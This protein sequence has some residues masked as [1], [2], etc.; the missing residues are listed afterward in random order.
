MSARRLLRALALAACGLCL[1]FA[2]RA[3]QRAEALYPPF[4]RL[5]NINVWARDEHAAEGHAAAIA[6]DI[7][8]LVAA[9]APVPLPAGDAGAPPSLAEGGDPR[10]APVVLGPNPCVIARAKDRYRFHVVI[11][12]PLGYHISDTISHALQ[13]AGAQKGVSVSVD[14]DAYDLM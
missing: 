6:C 11:K 1:F 10:V 13:R 9:T 3:A 14:I 7:R 4:V 2:L 8:R 12:S 5:S